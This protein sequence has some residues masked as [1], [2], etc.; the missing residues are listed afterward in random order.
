V[1]KTFDEAQL[2]QRVDHDVSFLAETVEML[3]ADAPPLLQSVRQAIVAGDAPGVARH[4]HALKGMIPN[5][6]AP[7]T[8]ASAHE[9]E[10]LGR[11]GALETAPQAVDALDHQLRALTDELSTF[12]KARS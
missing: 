2:L 6:C 11:S 7:Q 1:A 3:A 8:Q 4:A 5:F 9:V 12:V 10:R